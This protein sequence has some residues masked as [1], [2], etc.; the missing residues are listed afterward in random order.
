MRRLLAAMAAVGL[1][2]AGAW[3]A[4]ARPATAGE[5]SG[6]TWKVTS[7][8]GESDP[9]TGSAID[10]AAGPGTGATAGDPLDVDARGSIAYSGTTDQV[11]QHGTWKVTTSGVLNVPF[12]GT[13]RNDS[14]D[15]SYSGV[16][17]LQEHLTKTVPI[18]GDV[19]LLQGLIRVDFTATGANGA[20]CTASGYLYV[21]G[22]SFWESPQAVAA[23][24]LLV[25]ALALLFFATP[26]T[27]E[28]EMVLWAAVAGS[29]DDSPAPG[30]T[31]SGG[32][33]PE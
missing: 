11:I 8:H 16:E 5:A 9:P 13:V 3:T 24:L 32:R 15:L 12:E 30:A 31:R 33:T 29:V 18:L 6:C 20:T 27:I 23:T 28:P 21:G 19:V 17:P 26:R 4:S 14:G 25:L 22:A 2:T 10:T 1:F 7:Y